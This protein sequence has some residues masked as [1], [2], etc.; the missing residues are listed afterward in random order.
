MGDW[1]IIACEFI[2]APV[3]LGS[4]YNTSLFNW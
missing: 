2:S 1:K 4:T 3:N